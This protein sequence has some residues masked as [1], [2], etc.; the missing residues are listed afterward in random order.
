MYSD[1][2][3]S[4]DDVVVQAMVTISLRT[5][6]VPI[7]LELGKIILKSGTTCPLSEGSCLDSDDGYTFWKPLPDSACKFNQYDVLY[8]GNAI[9][10]QG[11][12][13][14]AT[15]YTLT[16]QDI[17]FALTLTCP[18][19]ICGYT[20]M[21]IEHPKLFIFETKRGNIFKT[22]TETPI[23]NLDLYIHKFKIRLCRK[24]YSDPDDGF[25]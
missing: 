5:V 3:G 24:A 20:I 19:V 15:I 14:G 1:Y 13:P 2:Y 25:V 16:T 17:T 22:K 10:M 11:N 9:K 4:W 18:H 8:E 6:Y 23:D 21:G 12:L 7:H